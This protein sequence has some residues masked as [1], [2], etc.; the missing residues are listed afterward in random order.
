MLFRDEAVKERNARLTGRVVIPAPPLLL[1]SSAV[2]AVVVLGLGLI[3][4][5]GHYSPR[6]TISGF[7]APQR[8]LGK[9]FAARPGKV[10]ALLVKEGDQVRLGQTLALISAEQALMDSEGKS[11]LERILTELAAEETRLSAGLGL[12]DETGASTKTRSNSRIA[13][14]KREIDAARLEKATL[15]QQVESAKSVRT[16]IEELHRAGYVTEV[17]MAVRRQQ[18]LE[19]ERQSHALAKVMVASET[20]L[21]DAELELKAQPA[22]TRQ[23]KSELQN[24]ISDIKRRVATYEIERGYALTAPLAG[25]VTALQA[26]PGRPV[27]SAQPV[28]AI[29]ADDA[30]MEAHLLVPSRAIG[31]VAEGQEV[32]L[33]Y[34]AFPYQHYGVHKARITEISRTTLRPEDLSVGLQLTEPVYRVKAKLDAQ[35]VRARGREHDLQSGMLLEGDILLEERPLWAWFVEPLLA[36]RGKV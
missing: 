19:L 10:D 16:R 23:R 22:Q 2:S 20:Q 27:T 30:V 6:Q 34:A 26:E 36:F 33:R 12:E 15:E 5:F 32:R 13:N 25:R 29:V 31:F 1:V 7:L 35:T 28:M 3:L 21:K 9:I 11:V 4:T 14:L 18:I 24:R 17:E 8:G